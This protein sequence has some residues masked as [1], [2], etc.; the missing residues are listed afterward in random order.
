MDSARTA[1]ETLIW[2]S[3]DA[4]EGD[5]DH[6]LLANLR[7][8]REED[9]AALPAGANARRSIGEILEH[10]GWAKWMYTDYAFGSASLACDQ[11]PMSPAGGASARPREELL[12]WLRGGMSA[13]WKRCVGWP[14]TPNWT[15]CG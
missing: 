6:S 12:A 14:T 5:P 2:L 9:W 13:G 3:D 11:P 1:I 7:E 8:L 15:S 4:F 10:V